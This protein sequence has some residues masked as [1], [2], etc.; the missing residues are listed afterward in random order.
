MHAV[1]CCAPQHARWTDVERRVV[2]WLISSA[3]NRLGV[4]VDPV[5]ATAFVILQRY[6]RGGFE[7]DCDLFCLV[8]AAL[9]TSCKSSDIRMTAS[10]IFYELARV[11]RN[12]PSQLVR[13][14]FAPD[15]LNDTIT[16]DGLI[17]VNR[18][19]VRILT[20]LNWDYCIEIPFHYLNHWKRMI[21]EQY[22]ELR[23][24]DWNKVIVDV[25]LMICSDYYLDVPP[26]VT[27]AVAAC[28]VFGIHDWM[29]MV[30]ERYGL[31]AWQLAIN[32]IQSEK[33]RTALC[34]RT[35]SNSTS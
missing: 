23:K 18:A 11:C 8:V 14:L 29:N 33:S 34:H 30:I 21:I 24:Q 16:N 1:A 13:T 2:W 15:L 3:R 19:E 28:D 27:A 20:L 32:S 5:V 4:A 6:F 17:A 35:W 9:L 10:T 7:S 31:D 25:C 26:E 12:A 22:P